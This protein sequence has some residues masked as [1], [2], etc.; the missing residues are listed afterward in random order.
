MTAA[1]GSQLS[2]VTSPAPR[3]LNVS[4][5]AEISALERDLAALCAEGL[6]EAYRDEHGVTR[7]R[8]TLTTE[9]VA[10]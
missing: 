9:A 6:L 1:A 5:F 7:Y 3:H 2:A 8:P 4:E 10:A